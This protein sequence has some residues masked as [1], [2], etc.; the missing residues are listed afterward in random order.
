[1]GGAVILT[2]FGALWAILSLAYW[3]ARPRSAIPTAGFVAAALL[4][5]SILRLADSKN[6]PKVDDPVESAKG[7]RAGMLFGII[8]GVEGGLIALSST[9]LARSWTWYLDSD[10][11]R[12]YRWRTFPPA[13]SR[14]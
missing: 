1:V 7:K 5:P 9:L 6:Y 8:F 13:G 4:A 14:F 3:A 12:V 2:F 11:R 10:C